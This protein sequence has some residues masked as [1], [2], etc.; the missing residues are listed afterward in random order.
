MYEFL[1]RCQA[2]SRRRRLLFFPPIYP[3]VVQILRRVVQNVSKI[4]HF[5]GTAGTD[6]RKEQLTGHEIKAPEQ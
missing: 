5:Q 6:R 3:P 4:E 2:I 1:L